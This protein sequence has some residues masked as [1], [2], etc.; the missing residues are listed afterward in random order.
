ML[1]DDFHIYELAWTPDFIETFIDDKLVMS[2]A[3]KDMYHLDK[4]FSKY[5]NIWEASN[6]PF[7]QEFYLILNVAVGG[8]CFFEDGK[9][10]KPWINRYEEAKAG[11][12]KEG[13]QGTNQKAVNEF[14]DRRAQWE[15]SWHA[16]DV[17]L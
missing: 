4:H 1:S 16:E 10:D 15:P 17:A 11:T 8:T 6:A 9:C 12:K 13:V 14:W 3:T 7:D 5:K 2:V